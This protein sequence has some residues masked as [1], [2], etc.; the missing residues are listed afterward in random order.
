M[1]QVIEV[2]IR[3][4]TPADRAA[5]REVNER[6]FGKPNEAN[7]VDAL[8]ASPAFIPDLSLVAE[9]DGAVVGHVMFSIVSVEGDADSVEVLALAPVAVRPEWQR[10]GIGG[11]LIRAGLERAVALG[12]RAV[13][14]IGHPTYYPRFGFTTARAFGIE[15]PFPLPDEVF[16]ALP[17]Q[18]GGLEGVRGNLVYPPAFREV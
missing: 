11:R 9:R 5:I 8:R 16:M 7:L 14:L 2:H 12:H 4:E 10:Q 15:P 18:P 6:A 13:V 17:L 1:S 3:P